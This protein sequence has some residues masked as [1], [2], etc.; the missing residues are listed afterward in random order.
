MSFEPAVDLFINLSD[1]TRGPLLKSAA[2]ITPGQ[3]P[4]WNQGDKFKLR[5]WF[6]TEAASANEAPTVTA[7]AGG[8]SIAI[9][10]RTKTDLEDGGLLFFADEFVAVGT[11]DDLHYEG[12]IDLNTE[13]LATAIVDKAR[14]TARVD[15]QIEQGGDRVTIPQF[16]LLILRDIYRGTE[17]VPTEGDPIYPTPDQVL[18]RAPANGSYRVVTNEDGTFM[19]FYNPTT[20]KY[21]TLFPDGPEGAVTTN[22]GP[23]EE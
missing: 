21:H 11:G 2:S 1:A 23:G 7:L 19:Q 12:D 9:A 10:G 14:L 16:D 3:T 15:I 6:L 5:L 22:W 18:V 4:V 17:G 13:P 20:G 8:A